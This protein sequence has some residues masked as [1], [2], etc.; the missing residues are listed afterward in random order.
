MAD[1][2]TQSSI[3][4]GVGGKFAAE[5]VDT[6]GTS[7]GDASSEQRA[8]EVARERGLG[9]SKYRIP[10]N[11]CRDY[12]FSRC[13]RAEC[14]YVHPPAD[15][16][17]FH[18]A[19]ASRPE[20]PGGGGN[21]S[22][23]AGFRERSRSP[24][25]SNHSAAAA[26]AADGKD[27]SK[28]TARS[29]A[30][31]AASVCRDFQ[32]GNCFRGKLC[33]FAHPGEEQGTEIAWPQICIDFRAGNCARDNCRLVPLLSL[34]AKHIT[35]IYQ[36]FQQVPASPPFFFFLLKMVPKALFLRRLRAGSPA[37]EVMNTIT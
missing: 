20:M 10:N 31:A 13:S 12:L 5:R 24:H 21:S 1:E 6:T 7:E 34:R 9:R 28:V 11:L 19:V 27:S 35:F 36:G 18:N 3:R 4:G 37:L 30:N 2:D 29:A 25:G 23:P 15:S 14:K 8:A 26:A 22:A 32:R 33:K 17:E 16:E